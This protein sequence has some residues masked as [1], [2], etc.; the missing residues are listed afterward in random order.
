VASCSSSQILIGPEG[1][2]AA[3]NTTGDDVTAPVDV[4]PGAAVVPYWE[5]VELSGSGDSTS[6]VD[7]AAADLKSAQQQRLRSPPLATCLDV[8]KQLQA[9]G[10]H[11][12][13]R[14]IPLS[15]ERTPVPS[16]LGDMMKQMLALPA[17]VGPLDLGS[18][19]GG[20]SA[21][22]AQ[23]MRMAA[24]CAADANRTWSGLLGQRSGS[25]GADA[26]QA[27][28]AEQ[29]QQ[30]QQPRSIVHLVV[31]RTATGSSA[32]FATA[33]FSTF[34]TKHSRSESKAAAAGAPS[35]P[36]KPGVGAAAANGAAGG[37][38][39]QGPAKRMRRTHSDL[40]EYRGIMSVARLLPGGLEVKGAVD[41]AIDRCSAI[42]NLRE[43][44][45]VGGAQH[46]AG[47]LR[48]ACVRCVC[49]CQHSACARNWTC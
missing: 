3:S 20:A 5:P 35:S 27:E 46:A 10:F 31:S 1:V 33:A 34:L 26:M 30:P 32:R 4:R 13:Y 19:G 16:D 8:A 40:G 41:E 25:G 6:P 21:R 45:K 7:V 24:Q 9:A 47:W 43:D 39:G 23:M 2:A 49:M 44:I 36:H 22:A 42:G 14:R 29:Q 28:L 12:T 38:P 11:I 18:P 15:R 48:C 37:S 17:G